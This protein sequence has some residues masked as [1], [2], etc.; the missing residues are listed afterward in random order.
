[1][2]FFSSSY[3]ANGFCLGGVD[4]PMRSSH[5]ISFYADVATSLWM[6]VMVRIARQR[7][8]SEAA[9]TPLAKNACSLFG[10]GV[11]HLLLAL[12]Y[13]YNSVGAGSDG[14]LEIFEGLSPRARLLAFACF[15]PVWYGFMTDKRRSLTTTAAFT[16]LHNSLQTF[17][18]PS[19]FFFTHVLLAVLLGSALRW[20]RRADADKSHYYALEAWLVDVPILLASFGEALSCD[21]LLIRYGGHVWFDMVVPI[22]FTAYFLILVND[23]AETR[24]ATEAEHDRLEKVRPPALVRLPSGSC[25]EGA[26]QVGE[27]CAVRR[28]PR[29]S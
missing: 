20:L 7:G 13:Y 21:A 2:R 8:L 3:L 29:C 22:G 25:S 1:V 24:C 10:H 11:G 19:R 12:R 15:T 14:A 9:R 6:M 23:P 26:G 27:P 17:L 4:S 18:L 5:A 16:L 28:R